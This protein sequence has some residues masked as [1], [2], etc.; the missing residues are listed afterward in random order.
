MT[1]FRDVLFQ[2]VKQ[3][4]ADTVGVEEPVQICKNVHTTGEMGVQIKEQA[5]ILDTSKGLVV[6]TGCAHPGIVDIVKKA[7]EVVKKD[8]DLVFGGFHLS[9]LLLLESRKSSLNSRTWA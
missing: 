7:K 4:G 8:I 6:I 5:L 9:R 3:T 1:A 2:D